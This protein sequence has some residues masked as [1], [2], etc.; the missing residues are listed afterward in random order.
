MEV[1]HRDLVETRIKSRIHRSKRFHVALGAIGILSGFMLASDS[2]AVGLT[3]AGTASVAVAA[4]IAERSKARN[5]IQGQI[6]KYCD[7]YGAAAGEQ[8]SPYLQSDLYHNGERYEVRTKAD[9]KATEASYDTIDKAALITL[10]PVVAAAATAA[11]N[12]QLLE[13]DAISAITIG[14][15]GGAY[16]GYSIGRGTSYYQGMTDMYMRQL[17]NI[18]NVTGR[19]NPEG[20]L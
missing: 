14:V 20:T 6:T 1:P 4:S 12:V 7:A 10:A 5:T 16:L 15:A 19:T 2:E 13:G 8:R 17:D 11:V 9:F 3:G 18:E